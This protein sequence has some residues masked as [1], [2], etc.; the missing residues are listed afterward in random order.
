VKYYD[1]EQK[2]NIDVGSKFGFSLLDELACVKGWDE[3]SESGIYSNEVRDTRAETLVVKSFKGGIIAEGFYKLIKDR[4]AAFGGHFVTNLYIAYKVGDRLALG[5]I[6]FKGAALSAWMDFHKA[7]RSTIYKKAVII[8][9]YSEGKKGKVIYRIPKFE[10]TEI[11]AE[12]N[13]AATQVDKELQEYLK[14]YFKRTRVEQA[15]PTDNAPPIT[16]DDEAR[17]LPPEGQEE[18][19]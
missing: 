19:W 2:K 10:L 6:Q 5:S 15:T 8:D 7:N 3:N 18:G 11:T 13:E 12:S 14:A 1:K 17:N 9:G 4:V 16:D